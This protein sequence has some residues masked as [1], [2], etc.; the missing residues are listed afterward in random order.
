[1]AFERLKQK[2]FKDRSIPLVPDTKGEFI[3]A[4]QITDLTAGHVNATM[5]LLTDLTGRLDP[6]KLNSYL[7]LKAISQEEQAVA[8]IA[9]AE[10]L[11]GLASSDLNNITETIDLRQKEGFNPQ[12]VYDTKFGEIREIHLGKDRGTDIFRQLNF[13]YEE[14]EGT[15]GNVLIRDEYIRLGISKS[16]VNSEDENDMVSLDF[17]VPAESLNHKS[18]RKVLNDIFTFEPGKSGGTFDEPKVLALT[19]SHKFVT[20]TKAYQGKRYQMNYIL[21]GKVVINGTER[22]V[23]SRTNSAPPGSKQKKEQRVPQVGAKLKPVLQT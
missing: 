11:V 12:M 7:K 18:D 1:L 17:I 16:Y 6:K 8:R 2:F 21:V 13:D 10:F 4:A 20:M 23:Y 22:E 14:H 19:P 5:S 3:P 15:I 9:I